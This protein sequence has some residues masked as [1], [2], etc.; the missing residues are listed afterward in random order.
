[1]ERIINNR[2]KW[3]IEKNRLLP[4]FQTGFR[5][6]CT[7]NDNLLRLETAINTGF[8]NKKT[9][10][11]IFLDLAKAY[12][13][14]R[15]TGLLYKITTLK[16]YG[17]VLRWI[18]NFITERNIAVR[19][20]NNLSPDRKLKR[21]VPQGCV[22][23]PLLFNIMMSD[24][25]NPDDGCEISLFA[26]DIEIHSTATTKWETERNL[27]K[28]LKKIE[29]WAKQWKL[30]FS[31]PKCI[32]VTFSRRR[33]KERDLN[34]IHNNSRITEKNN[35]KFLGIIFD[36]R[37]TW[38]D[39]IEY[40]NASL[41]R[42]ANCIKTLTHGKTPLQLKLL[43]RIYTAM[44][45]SKLDYGALILTTIPKTKLKKLETTQNQILRG[46]LGCFK[47]TPIPLIQIETGISPIKDRWDMLATRYLTNLSTKTWN[48]AYPSLY[49]MAKKKQKYGNPGVYQQCQNT[50]QN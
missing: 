24:F 37:L 3:Y 19:V 42:R 13:S 38:D 1:M 21:G 9:T 30:T 5:N 11:A 41:H 50:S 32:A 46:I 10:S 12:D 48:S 28:Y 27:Q 29:E 6:G 25:P 16:I 23:S 35:F 34:L 17:P 45:R 15:I 2:L 39:H 49:K 7:T 44:I 14:T 26:D 40:I 31:V 43:V 33:K 20:D 18:K 4:I 36:S 22:L 47:S 8:D